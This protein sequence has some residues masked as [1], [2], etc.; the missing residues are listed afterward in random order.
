MQVISKAL[1]ISLLLLLSM[2]CNRENPRLLPDKLVGFWTTDALHYEDRF[3]ELDKAYVIIG[4]GAHE[5][6]IV[7]AIS[8]V[9]GDE[10]GSEAAYAIY[11]TDQQGNAY[12]MMVLFNPANGGEIRFKNQPGMWKRYAD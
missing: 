4:T 3:L 7:Q 8:K 5:V 10:N 9:Q 12:Q 2:A 11:S 1:P 6:P